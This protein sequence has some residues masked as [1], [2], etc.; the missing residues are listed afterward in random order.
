MIVLCFACLE[1]IYEKISIFSM[2]VV[3]FITI[4]KGSCI[5]T[6]QSTS[7][8]HTSA[9]YTCNRVF[10]LAVSGN[11]S[12]FLF[13]SPSFLSTRSSIRLRRPVERVG[14]RSARRR[15]STFRENSTNSTSLVRARLVGLARVQLAT[16]SSRHC[17]CSRRMRQLRRSGVGTVLA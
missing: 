12:S 14:T 8:F 3:I 13:H 10:D 17:C 1:H 11:R 2:L 7:Q 4:L 16:A 6:V 5:E 15:A 9:L